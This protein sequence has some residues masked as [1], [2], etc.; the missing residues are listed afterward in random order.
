MCWY[1]IILWRIS[2][3]LLWEWAPPATPPRSWEEGR[4]IDDPNPSIVIISFHFHYHRVLW[5][6]Y[7]RIKKELAL[8]YPLDVLIFNYFMKDFEYLVVSSATGNYWYSGKR[9]S[10]Y[11]CAFD[12]GTLPGLGTLSVVISVRFCVVARTTRKDLFFFKIYLTRI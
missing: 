6:D 10:V 8:I 1:S 3:I 7:E 9:K 2:N 11:Q 5:Y 4:L 12:R